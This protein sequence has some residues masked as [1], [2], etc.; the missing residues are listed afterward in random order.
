M[1]GEKRITGWKNGICFQELELH[2]YI[3]ESLSL[4]DSVSQ[5]VFPPTL[6]RGSR[7]TKSIVS[8]L[9]ETNTLANNWHPDYFMVMMN[10]IVNIM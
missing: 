8:R 6:F 3:L 5:E 10:S 2:F 9:Y 1:G 4:Q 7:K